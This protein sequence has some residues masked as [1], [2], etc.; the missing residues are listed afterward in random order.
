[1]LQ[2]DFVHQK[3]FKSNFNWVD[4]KQVLD[5]IQHLDKYFGRVNYIK[6]INFKHYMVKHLV[7]ESDNQMVE[8]G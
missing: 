6:I 7:L 4:H 5:S 3:N 8:F 2:L 1:M